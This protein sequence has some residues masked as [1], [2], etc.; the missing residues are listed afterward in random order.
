MAMSRS[1]ARDSFTRLSAMRMSPL[2]MR[3]RP[4]MMRR[5]GGCAASRRAGEDDELAVVDLE[6]EIVEGGDSGDVLNGD[7]GHCR[8]MGGGAGGT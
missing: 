6:G 4:A 1:E 8:R 7:F 3:S 2:E 5:S